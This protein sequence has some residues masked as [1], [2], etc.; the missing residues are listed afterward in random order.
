MGTEHWRQVQELYHAA[1]ERGRGVLANADPDLRRQVES[2]LE[3][4]ERTLLDRPAEQSTETD[5]AGN[6]PEEFA[7]QLPIE[8]TGAD[9]TALLDSAGDGPANEPINLDKPRP[10]WWMWLLAAAFLTHIL[11]M[12]AVS[13]FGPESSGVGLTGADEH[14]LIIAIASSSPAE[15]AGLRSGSAC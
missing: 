1:Q 14:P 11:F 9:S 8:D 2:L 13:F 10:P 15:R 12:G 4:S 3:D 6:P 5:L 7:G